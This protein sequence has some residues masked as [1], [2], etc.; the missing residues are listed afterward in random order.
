M[1]WGWIVGACVLAGWLVARRRREARGV[2]AAVLVAIA[3]ALLVGSGVVALPNVTKLL[4][5]A[6]T[7]LGP[8]TY[9]VVGLLA[10]AETG[11]FVGLVVPGET[12]VIVGGVVAGQGRSRCSS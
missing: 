12:A 7:T 9:L 5:D 6:G 11:A 3:V 1:R 2:Q 4:K 8:W 10:F